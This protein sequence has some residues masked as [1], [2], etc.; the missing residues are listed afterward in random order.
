MLI[1]SQ[2]K[3]VLATL[4]LLFDIEVSGGVISARRDMSWCCL[5]GKYSTKEKAM[6]VLDMI[7]EAYG[8]SEY[9]KYVIPEVC[10]ILSM[11]PKTEENKAHAGELGEMLKNGMTFQMPEDSEVEV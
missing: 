11:K 9:T 2:N 3:E 1:R 10:R 6:K 5:L 8:D 4:E 7:Q